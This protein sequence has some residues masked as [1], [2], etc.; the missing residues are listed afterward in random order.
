M[1]VGPYVRSGDVSVQ[2][3]GCPWHRDLLQFNCGIV[4]QLL[5]FSVAN[6]ICSNNSI[7]E[8]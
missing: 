1:Q 4:F 7:V 8:E 5:Q 3:Q 2:L 6:L